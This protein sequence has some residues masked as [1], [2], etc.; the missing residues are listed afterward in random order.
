MKSPFDLLKLLPFVLTILSFQWLSAQSSLEISAVTADARAFPLSVMGSTKKPV[1]YYDPQEAK[2][3]GI[4]AGIFANDLAEIS[5]VTGSRDKIA[6]QTDTMVS[7]E[8]AV[9]VG[10]LEHSYLIQQLVK[11]GWINPTRLKDQWERFQILVLNKPFHK[12]KR[13]LVIIGSDR[14]GAAYGLMHLSRSMGVHPFTWWADIPAKKQTNLYIKGSYLSNPPSVKYRGI[15][16]NDEDWG[17]QPWAAAN[18]DTNIKDIGP[19]T[20]RKIFELMLRLKANY[21]WPAMHP[22]TKAFYY[23]PEN[24]QLADDYAIVVGGSHCEPML[25]NNVFEWTENFEKE[26]GKKPGEWRYDLNGKEIYQY[27]D[28]RLKASNKFESLYTVGMRGIHDGSMPGPKDT[29]LKLNL[30]QQV[31]QDQRDILS[32]RVSVPVSKVP[33]VFVP[34]KEV[35]SLY[36]RGMVLPDDITIM[37]PDDNHGYIRQFPDSAE[38]KRS[39]GHGIYYHLSYWGRPYDYL[40]LS[41]ISPALM[42]FELMEA[43]KAKANRIWIFNVGDIKPAEAEIQFAMDMAWDISVGGT[44]AKANEYLA[45]W[46]AEIFGKQL[47][48]AIAAVKK[49]Y[50]RLAS[51]A[52]PEHLSKV[53]FQKN[54]YAQRINAYKDLARLS[55]SIRL[56]IPVYLQDAYF[57]LISYPVLSAS[58]MNEKMGLRSVNAYN[59]IQKLTAYFNDSLSNG[60]WK[61]MMSWH[62]RDQDV[63]KMPV[64]IAKP[65]GS[66]AIADT[67]FLRRIQIKSY[68]SAIPDKL[69][70]FLPGLG[71]Q[72]VGIHFDPVSDH[73]TLPLTPLSFVEPVLKGAYLLEITCLPTHAKGLNLPMNIE[74]NINHKGYQ[75]FQTDVPAETG[76]WDKA[77]LE[78]GIKY[79]VPVVMDMD[80]NLLIQIKMTSRRVVL[81]DLKLFEVK[82]GD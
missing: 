8:N 16:L 78:G 50:Y 45:S 9:I 58:W 6:V 3:V 28:D 49:E 42:S 44:A 61:Q 10:T 30:L 40:W 56:N 59:N 71:P 53:L 62:P 67:S 31:I 82:N 32:K 17:L 54:E 24:P 79:R 15:F 43:Y 70:R 13:L 69:Y 11:K 72:G 12:A 47:S 41:S 29:K 63:F 76:A 80:G 25:R 1:I 35:L 4:A 39:G 27:W 34:Y 21:I 37:W 57:Q 68:N 48:P 2:V 7:A 20:Y 38:Q 26:Y 74:L 55:D 14:R 66:S 64:D 81:S 22:C 75:S 60:K 23:Y 51:N 36:Q 19:N 73:F 5:I 33:Q 52:K 18:L 77:I 46:A 65:A